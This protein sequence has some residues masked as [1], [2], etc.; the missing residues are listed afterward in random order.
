M[1]EVTDEFVKNAH[2]LAQAL[3]TLLDKAGE[4]TKEAAAI[5]SQAEMVAD[6]LVGQGLIKAGEKGACASKLMS[7]ED[8]LNILNKTAQHVTAPSMGSAVEPTAEKE[9][10][11][12]G[13][14]RNEDAGM[15]AS[16]RALLSKLG[17]HV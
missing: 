14:M 8:T 13:G 11:F 15:A 12:N 3:P 4:N 7:H 16:D 6:T 17:F 1:P 2:A 10:S 9:S 5:R